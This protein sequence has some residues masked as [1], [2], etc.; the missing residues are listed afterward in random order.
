MDN[1][2]HMPRYCFPL[3]FHT[4]QSLLKHIYI[5]SV[6]SW[7]RQV[8]KNQDLFTMRKITSANT[9]A[10][11]PITASEQSSALPVTWLRLSKSD[12]F[13]THLA[14]CCS[15]GGKFNWGRAAVFQ[16]PA[17]LLSFYPALRTRIQACRGFSLEKKITTK[18]QEMFPCQTTF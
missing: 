5:S 16:L 12:C 13:Y 9:S 10:G 17:A 18:P 2:T 7:G 14:L 3:R 11:R 4:G 6:S 1:A 8:S 15:G